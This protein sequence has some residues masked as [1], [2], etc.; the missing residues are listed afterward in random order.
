MIAQIHQQVLSQTYILT[1]N[2]VTPITHEL[3]EDALT[4]LYK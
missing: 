1:L 3:M 2:T 4:I